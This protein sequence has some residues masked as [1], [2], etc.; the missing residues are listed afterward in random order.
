MR[1]LLG[2]MGTKWRAPSRRFCHVA[3]VVPN[4]ALFRSCGCAGVF[5]MVCSKFAALCLHALRVTVCTRVNALALATGARLTR[6]L[7]YLLLDY[8][9]PLSPTSQLVPVMRRPLRPV[10][11]PRAHG[12]PVGR[13][14]G[15]RRR[16]WRRRRRFGRGVEAPETQGRRGE[17]HRPRTAREEGPAIRQL[18][19]GGAQDG[20]QEGEPP[21]GGPCGP[22][23]GQGG[24][25]EGP[26]RA[27]GLASR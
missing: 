24:R 14:A 18:Q 4:K 5:E 21:A 11:R 13:G 25:S 26:K 8:P 2:E 1:A 17:A 23:P 6:L 27:G 12:G 7:N 22:R 9:P 20:V 10:P 16:K 3:K 19:V 15:R